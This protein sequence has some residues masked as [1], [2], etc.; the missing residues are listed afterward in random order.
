MTRGHRQAELTHAYLLGSGI[1]SLAAAAHLIHDAHV[2]PSHIHILESG[3][4]GMQ[5]TGTPETGYVLWPEQ[6]LNFSCVC[7]Y[8]LLSIIPSLDNP[9]KT[10]KQEI[11]EFNAGLDNKTYENSRIIARG[12]GGPLI[13]DA[14]D[15]G[16][17]E[18]DRLDLVTIFMESDKKLSGLKVTDCF[19]EAFF[20]TN[21]WSM[22]ATMQVENLPWD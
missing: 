4:E 6:M 17:R 9:A 20:R 2:P 10:V 16:L 13:V 18:K 5:K 21:F 3:E 1:A 14:K 22:W 11:D 15:L 8:D 7:L 12:T 19:E